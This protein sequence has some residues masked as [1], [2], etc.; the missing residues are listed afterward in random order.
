MQLM[1]DE[2]NR[3]PGTTLVLVTHD[4]QR[5]CGRASEDRAVGVR[6]HRA[7]SRFITKPRGAMPAC[8]SFWTV[9]KRPV[10]A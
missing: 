5:H 10:P 3:E 2:L 6:L 7:P 9:P 8:A 1:F 4:A